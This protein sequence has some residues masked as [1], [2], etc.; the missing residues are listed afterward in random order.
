MSQWTKKAIME[1]F[2][3][4]IEE[5]P[6]DRI[7]VKEIVMDCGVTRNTFYY[8]FEDVFALAKEV[9]LERLEQASREYAPKGDWENFIL[10][11]VRQLGPKKRTIRHLF[12]TAK[13]NELNKVMQEIVLYAMNLLFD[14]LAEGKQIAPEER[15]LIIDF[16]RHSLVGFTRDWLNSNQSE[17]PEVLVHRVSLL[18]QGGMKQA[19]LEA[20]SLKN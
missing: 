14:H 9:L 1:S 11:L 6:L 15:A 12:R 4:M 17:I 18:L 5:K 8:H 13:S 7:T 3:R 10:L 19:I 20:E 2:E 16:Y